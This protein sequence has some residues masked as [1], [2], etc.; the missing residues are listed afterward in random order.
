[1]SRRIQP[2]MP[3]VVT[4]GEN[5]RFASLSYQRGI[6][7]ISLELRYEV[8]KHGLKQRAA[9]AVLRSDVLINLSDD[10]ADNVFR[11]LVVIAYASQHLQVADDESLLY[12]IRRLSVFQICIR[13]DVY[14]ADFIWLGSNVTTAEDS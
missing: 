10:G 5:E 2:G 8:R 1:M 11:N 13:P 7:G 12:V 4:Q 14:G 3:N 6:E 9:G